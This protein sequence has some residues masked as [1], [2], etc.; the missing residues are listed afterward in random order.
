MKIYKGDEVI[1]TLG[2]DKG[3]KGK[4][5]KILPKSKAV[6]VN[7]VNLYKRHVKRQSRETKGQIVEITKPLAISKVAVICPSCKKPTRIGYKMEG[8]EKKR[9]CK[10]CKKIIDNK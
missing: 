2:K 5:E 10:K 1:V 7:G 6:V 4:V 3:K 9:M 8:Q